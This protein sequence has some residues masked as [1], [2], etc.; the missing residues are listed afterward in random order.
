MASSK[1]LIMFPLCGGER[2]KIM[3]IKELWHDDEKIGEIM[4]D[5][6]LS[7]EDCFELLHVD[8][9][10]QD[11]GDPRWDYELFKIKDQIPPRFGTFM[12]QWLGRKGKNDKKRKNNN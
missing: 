12:D 3:M 6:S 8:L 11:G 10:E 5:H 2:T 4:T 9:T 1:L 7:L